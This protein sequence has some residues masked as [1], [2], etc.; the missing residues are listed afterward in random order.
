MTMETFIRKQP[1][2]QVSARLD[3]DVLEV[4]QHVAEVERRPISSVVRNVLSDWAKA[5]ENQTSNE[6]A[7]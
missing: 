7:A 5:R 3:P 4:V 1:R 6:A 2:D